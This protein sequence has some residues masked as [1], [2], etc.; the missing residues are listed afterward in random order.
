M[1]AQAPLI[2]SVR[3]KCA[4]CEASHLTHS[5]KQAVLTKHIEVLIARMCLNGSMAVIENIKLLKAVIGNI[6]ES[7][8]LLRSQWYYQGVNG[9]TKKSM[10]LS[11][12]QWYY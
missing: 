2:L 9:I 12:S 7:M 3:S 8:V 6:K 5:T 10:V 4:M 1:F 11:R